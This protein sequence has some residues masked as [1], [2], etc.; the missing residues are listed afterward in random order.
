MT[1]LSLEQRLVEGNPQS[2]VRLVVYEDL[3]CGDCRNLRRLLD[4]VVLPRYAASIAIEHRDFPLPKHAWAWPA[5]VAARHFD[6]QSVEA[7]LNFRR[8][9][10][11]NLRVITFESL[12]EHLEQFGGAPIADVELHRLVDADYQEGLARGVEKTPTVFVNGVPF[13]ERFPVDEFTAA[14]ES[15][16][17]E[18]QQ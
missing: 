4:E 8:Y 14:I 6:R 10:L 1:L 15:A 7:G 18:R 11:E 5:A 12:K 16:I 2:P 9:I 17:A 13:V 3:Q